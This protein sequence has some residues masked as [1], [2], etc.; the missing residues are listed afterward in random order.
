L[1]EQIIDDWS[2]FNVPENHPHPFDKLNLMK[3]AIPLVHT[4]R[5]SIKSYQEDIDTDVVRVD[6]DA[7]EWGDFN[8]FKA[9]SAS[10]SK[11]AIKMMREVCVLVDDYE[12]EQA[13]TEAKRE[14]AVAKRLGRELTAVEGILM[15]TALTELIQKVFSGKN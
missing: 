13:M 14:K 10:G 2:M 4:V 3:E 7:W 11:K 6:M 8:K 15:M 5:E 12:A 1:L 9:L